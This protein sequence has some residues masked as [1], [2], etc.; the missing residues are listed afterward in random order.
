MAG[1][2]INLLK[3]P[4]EFQSKQAGI[5][6][7]LL[8]KHFGGDRRRFVRHEA[9]RG[10]RGSRHRQLHNLVLAQDVGR[11]NAGAKRAYIERLGQLNKLDPRR[12]GGAQEDGHLQPNPG[13][14]ALVAILQFLALLR[15]LS[16]HGDVPVVL[17][18]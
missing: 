8:P 1:S 13:R 16:V 6:Y 5:P 18:N 11:R 2:G 12:I 3:R 14:P 4:E 17:A 10:R 7:D 9:R 15:Q